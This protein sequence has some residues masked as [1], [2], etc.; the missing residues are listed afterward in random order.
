MLVTNYYEELGISETSSLDDVKKSI[1]S[2]RKRYRQLTGSP[3]IDQR[4]MAERKMEIIAQAEKVFEN[5]ETRKKYDKE[6][7]ISKHSSEG[8]PDST[9]TN[10]SNTSYLDSARQAF[11]SGKKSLA[12]SYIEEALKINRNDADVWY[13]K[14]MISLEDSN[15]SDAELAISEAN[16]LRPNNADILSLLGDVYCEK[17][18]QKFAIQYYQEAFELS[19]NSFYLLKKGRSLFLFEQYKQ[20]AKDL[21]YLYDHFLEENKNNEEYIYYL[22]SSCYKEIGDNE[23]AYKFAKKLV[24]IT[25]S[26]D[27]KL[28]YAGILLLKSEDECENYLDTLN[29]RYGNNKDFQL[30]YFSLLSG[31]TIERMKKAPD[32]EVEAFFRKYIDRTKYENNAVLDNKARIRIAE[33]YLAKAQRLGIEDKIKNTNYYNDFIDNKNSTIYATTRHSQGMG[34]FMFILVFAANWFLSG[35]FD[36]FVHSFWISNA[37]SLALLSNIVLYYNYPKGWQINRRKKG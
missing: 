13:F 35:F 11:Y 23:E 8:T 3:N 10:H 34:C 5:E 36:K 19:N 24:D 28:H 32:T 18:Q 29:E 20:A 9:P 25:D 17:D 31:I 6:L 14:A 33:A 7:E 16:R 26:L 4:S 21:R 37:L 30:V 2:N 22:L 15:L 27:N 12:Y 1:K